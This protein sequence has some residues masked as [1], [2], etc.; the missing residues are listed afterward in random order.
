MN[1]KVNRYI[2]TQTRWDSGLL[3]PLLSA[4]HSFQQPGKY[5]GILLRGAETVGLFDFV[6]E[7]KSSDAQVNID[8]EA[9]YQHRYVPTAGGNAF[10]VNP[11]QPTAFYVARGRG[12]YSVV[13]YRSEAGRRAPEFDSRELKDGDVF[14]LTPIRHGIYSVT[15]NDA[16]KGEFHVQKRKGRS[17]PTE[18][19]II[20]CTDKGFRP[21]QVRTEFSQPL[22]FVIRTP[23]RIK[24]QLEKQPNDEPDHARR[25]SSRRKKDAAR[26]S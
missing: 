2:L 9:I 22:F 23:S 15:N 12:G 19:V 26:R 11:R 8:L 14:T 20:E 16:A 25:T 17:I 18:P 7:E 21:D 1:A 24:I 13:V 10:V 3:T 6:V 5:Q 4:M